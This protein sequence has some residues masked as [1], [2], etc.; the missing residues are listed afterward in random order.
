MLPL[1]LQ[2]KRSWGEAGKLHTL[3]GGNRAPN[4]REKSGRNKWTAVNKGR[5]RREWW[6]RCGMENCLRTSPTDWGLGYGGL[7]QSTSQL[8][9]SVEIKEANVC[10]VNL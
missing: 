1:G 5:C 4:D 7:L 3:V 2:M 9:L 6:R 10:K 8:S